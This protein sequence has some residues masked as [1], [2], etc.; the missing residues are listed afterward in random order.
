MLK[1]AGELA[2]ELFEGMLLDPPPSRIVEWWLE[3][4]VP[5]RK[6][7]RFTPGNCHPAIPAPL[8]AIA[9]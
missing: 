1:H 6:T 3:A 2:R 4:V 7:D 5:V 8:R 9:A